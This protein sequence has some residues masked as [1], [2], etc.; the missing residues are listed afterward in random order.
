MQLSDSNGQQICGATCTRAP[1]LWDALSFPLRLPS[2]PKGSVNDRN[3]HK[4]DFFNQKSSKV[5][6]LDILLIK[7]HRLSTQCL[8]M[9]LWL[10]CIHPQSGDALSARSSA[11]ST[12]GTIEHSAGLQSFPVLSFPKSGQSHCVILFE[13]LKKH[14]KKG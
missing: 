1:H 11:G 8:L 4:I 3:H 9:C 10:Q 2:R 5:F 7:N 14:T 12:H 13:P 6:F